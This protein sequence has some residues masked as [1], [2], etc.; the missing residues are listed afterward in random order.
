MSFG[1]LLNEVVN[2]HAFTCRD[3]W[4]K[5][6][7]LLLALASLDSLPCTRYFLTWLALSNLELGCVGTFR[8]VAPAAFS[9][10][11]LW[12]HASTPAHH[13]PT[14]GVSL[15]FLWLHTGAVHYAPLKSL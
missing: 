6:V 1:S 15:G 3:P 10:G 11:F 13:S 9:L 7:L 8:K 5:P 4:L 14:P 12:L 2:Q